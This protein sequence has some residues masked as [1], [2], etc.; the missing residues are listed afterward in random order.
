MVKDVTSF[1]SLEKQLADAEH[2]ATLGE[3]S[4]GLA[5]EIKNP[6]AGIKGAIDVIRDSLPSDGKHR[7]ILGDVIHEVN[8]IDKIVRDLSELRQTQAAFA[9][10]I[11]LP[12]LVQRIVA[13]ARA[14]SKNEAL[15]DP[16]QASD[17]DPGI[18]RG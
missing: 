4:A 15:S 6:L 5:H 13:I 10:P 11:D 14:T 3:L 16:G 2:L 17:A 9:Q 18:Y 7:E 8:R 12:E 1:R